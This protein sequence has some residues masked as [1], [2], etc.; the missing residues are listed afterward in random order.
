MSSDDSFTA[1][2]VNAPS[3]IASSPRSESPDPIDLIGHSNFVQSLEKSTVQRFAKSL[4]ATN[5]VGYLAGRAKS[6]LWDEWKP[7]MDEELAKM[8][9]YGVWEE[10]NKEAWMIILTGK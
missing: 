4:L 6:G 10:V 1:S 3:T 5:P 9:K 8:T 7:T 2:T